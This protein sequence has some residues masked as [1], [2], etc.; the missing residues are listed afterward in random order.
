MQVEEV[1]HKL[2]ATAKPVHKKRVDLQTPD[3]GSL[4]KHEYKNE[5]EVDVLV[6]D[7]F[8]VV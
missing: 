4:F 3:A 6:K 7:S 5:V 1:M 8:V 2:T